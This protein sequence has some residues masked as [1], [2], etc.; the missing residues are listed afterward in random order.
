[1]YETPHFGGSDNDDET[2]REPRIED[3]EPAG[4]GDLPEEYPKDVP[5]IQEVPKDRKDDELPIQIDDTD[6]DDLEWK[7]KIGNQEIPEA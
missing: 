4:P 3:E 5:D 2:I 1:M 6:L 7:P